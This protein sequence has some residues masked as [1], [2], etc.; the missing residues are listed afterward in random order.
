VQE[1]AGGGSNQGSSAQKC[2]APVDSSPHFLQAAFHRSKKTIGL[3][4]TAS[5]Y[6]HQLRCRAPLPPGLLQKVRKVRR[7]ESSQNFNFTF[8]FPSP[9]NTTNRQSNRARL[10]GAPYLSAPPTPTSPSPIVKLEA[11]L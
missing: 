2:A 9:T 10:S 1:R 6:D 11:L 7:I 3:V 5:S 8:T 4:A